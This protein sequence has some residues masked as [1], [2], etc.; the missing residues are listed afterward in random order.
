MCYF[1]RLERRSRKL[2][3]NTLTFQNSLKVPSYNKVIDKVKKMHLLIP[4]FRIV[5]WDIGV[6]STG[7]PILIEYNTYHQDITIHQ[8]ANGPLFGAFTDEILNIGSKQY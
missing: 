2:K 3:I 8:L 4:Y 7:I 6:D 1:R 5:S